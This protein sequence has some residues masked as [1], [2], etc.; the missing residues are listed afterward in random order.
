MGRTCGKWQNRDW[1]PGWSS[2]FLSTVRLWHCLSMRK[3]AQCAGQGPESHVLLPAGPN[4]PTTPESKL[5]CDLC[6]SHLPCEMGSP[7]ACGLGTGCQ[8]CQPVS[9]L[10]K[11]KTSLIT[12]VSLTSTVLGTPHFSWVSMGV[13]PA[14]VGS[15]VLS[16]VTFPQAGK[17]AAL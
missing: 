5:S 8:V 2:S 4:D 9:C 6:H 3:R 11:A 10:Q 13:S 16:C 14:S 7:K 1:V 17:S 15:S 12:V